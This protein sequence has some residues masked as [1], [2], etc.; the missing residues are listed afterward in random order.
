MSPLRT[1]LHR[2]E[3]WARERVRPTALER[4]ETGRTE[5]LLREGLR[6]GMSDWLLTDGRPN[7][8]A[9]LPSRATRASAGR[10]RRF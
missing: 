8:S 3:A 6:A 1:D 10:H 4:R 5:E 2:I 9:F 7:W